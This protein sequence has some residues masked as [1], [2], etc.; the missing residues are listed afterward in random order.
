MP[1]ARIPLEQRQFGP[2]ASFRLPLISLLAGAV[3]IF[4]G[5]VA[6]G[7]YDL[8]ALLTNITY[9][10]RLSVHFPRVP[11]HTTI[12]PWIILMPVIGGVIIGFMAKYGSEK[13]KGHGIPEAMEAVLMSRSRD[14]SESRDPEADLGGN[15]D[16]HGRPV[17]R[18]GPDHSDGRRDG[19]AGGP[20]DFY[21]GCG[22]QGAARVRC[23]RR[24]GG[25]VQHAGGHAVILAIELL[26]FEFRSRSFI[27]LVIAS[28]LATSMRTILLGQHSMFSVTGA[29]FD[30]LY[31]FAVV[32]RARIS[33]YADL[34]P[35]ALRNCSTG[36]KINS[37][38]C[39]STNCGIRRSGCTRTRYHR[40]LRA[41]RA[42]CGLRHDL[43]TFWRAIWR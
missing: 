14:S 11:E 23:R 36:W 17:W 33:C 21:D 12:G 31:W 20:T 25:H 34:R 43:R 41:A 13:I 24:Y 16:W 1:S 22:A 29:N 18:G 27:P 5:L 9:Y 26:L 37:T 35:S 39:P 8:I 28:T 3:G 38:G 15:R 19:F 7:L 10:H 30:P 42:W 40:I 32:P 4:A 2:T 6:Y